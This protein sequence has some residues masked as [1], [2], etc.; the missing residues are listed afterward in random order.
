VINAQWTLI[1]LLSALGQGFHIIYLL[2]SSK[3]IG[4]SVYIVDHRVDHVLLLLAHAKWRLVEQ[5]WANGV[6]NL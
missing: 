4:F 1:V 5:W 2:T 3:A 6:W